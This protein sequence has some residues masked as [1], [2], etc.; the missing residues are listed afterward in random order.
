MRILLIA[1]GLVAA[2]AI[3]PA[4]HADGHAGHGGTAAA[5]APALTEPGQAAF[6]ALAEIVAAL[7]ADAG[8]DWPRV[9]VERLRRHLTDMDNA[10]LAASA[11]AADIPGGA[12]FTV[13]GPPP[14]AASLRRMAAAHART[15]N[16]AR[17]WSY[18]LREVP[19]GIEM[20]VAGRG[21]GDAARIRALGFAGI[22]AQGGHH[23]AHHLAI[24]SG[25]DPH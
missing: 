7:E 16:G 25:A 4:Q 18:G 12:R 21:P 6:A 5:A 10:V 1:L 11:E 23:Q 3:A 8:T 13:T 19:G 2:P 24:A 9:D 14:V 15:M 17:G 22:L 20:E